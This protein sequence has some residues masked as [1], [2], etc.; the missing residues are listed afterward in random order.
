MHTNSINTT[1]LCV[2]ATAFTASIFCDPW[3]DNNKALTT[4]RNRAIVHIALA[5]ISQYGH[6]L[7]LFAT[8]TTRKTADYTN[9]IKQARLSVIAGCFLALNIAAE[10]LEL[11]FS[12]TNSNVNDPAQLGYTTVSITS[13][14]HKIH[15]AASLISNGSR[16]ASEA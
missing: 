8:E 1:A 4:I 12:N 3:T 14:F 15:L 2:I 13:I 6:D 7:I 5:S 10:T 16:A 11:L 9:T